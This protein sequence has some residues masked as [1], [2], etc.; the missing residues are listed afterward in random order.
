[1]KMSF[2][3]KKSPKNDLGD[4]LVNEVK[5]QKWLKGVGLVPIYYTKSIKYVLR[6]IQAGLDGFIC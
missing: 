5:S 4:P 1:M 3:V 6:T 2:S